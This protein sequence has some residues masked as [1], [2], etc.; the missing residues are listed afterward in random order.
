MGQV[1]VLNKKPGV[2]LEYVA[3]LEDL[4]ARAR[5]GEDSGFA[6]VVD[7]AN[8]K[9]RVV[10]RGSFARDNERAIKIASKALDSFCRWAGVAHP[11]VAVHCPVPWQVKKA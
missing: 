7:Q 1:Y 6:G 10:S 11:A 4:L 3:L 8:G 5:R 9:P 2:D